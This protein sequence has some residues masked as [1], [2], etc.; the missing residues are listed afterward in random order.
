MLQSPTQRLS[1]HRLLERLAGLPS[2]VLFILWV[3]MILGFGLMFFLLSAHGDG[4]HGVRLLM[5]AEGPWARFGNAVYFSIITA[6][7]LGY[8]DLTPVGFSKV[9]A[10]GEAMLGF[11]LLAVFISKLVSQKQETALYNIH[12][13]TFQNAFSTTREGF[14]I[15]RRDCDIMAAQVDKDGLLDEKSQSNLSVVFQKAQT[16][17]EGI[18]DFY[19]D[20]DWYN[21]DVRREALLLDAV[22]RTLSRFSSLVQVLDRSAA[23]WRS[24]TDIVAELHSV[25]RLGTT[26]VRSWRKRANRHHAAWFTKI[27]GVLRDLSAAS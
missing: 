6:T 20:F 13:L 9:L 22:H 12:K 17:M 16:L 3:A 15:L 10:A 21:I 23:S 25:H 14:F 11:F 1:L 24:Q 4:S 19:D 18:L 7:T 26:V 8:G 27:H 5:E 2:R